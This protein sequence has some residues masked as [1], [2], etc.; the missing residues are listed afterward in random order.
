[1]LSFDDIRVYELLIDVS[2]QYGILPSMS[3]ASEEFFRAMLIEYE[4]DETES[5]IRQWLQE[6]IAS[7]FVAFGERPKWIQS[8]E[9]PF[10]RGMPMVFVGQLD[11]NRSNL[12][13]A[14]EILHDDTSYYVFIPHQRASPQVIVQQY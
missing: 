2:D 12:N 9:W 1:M 13:I 8:P 3:G 10:F 5:D 4:G 6:R 14:R 7:S 11:I